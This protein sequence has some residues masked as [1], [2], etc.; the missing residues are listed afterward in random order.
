MAR[1]IRMEL[2]PHERDALLKGNF[3]IDDVRAFYDQYYTADSIVVGVGG[4]GG[5]SGPERPR[6]RANPT[7]T[8]TT[9]APP[10]PLLGPAE[11]A[12]RTAWSADR[13]YV[14]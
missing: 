12:A 14:D 11:V 6:S 9:T 10:P 2:L 13:P 7:P 8:T 5:A 1:Q 4:G 3:T